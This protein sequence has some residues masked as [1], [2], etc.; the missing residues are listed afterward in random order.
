MTAASTPVRARLGR[1]QDLEA[2]LALEQAFAEGDRVSR[3]SWRRFI[4][5]ND[6][7]LVIDQGSMLAAAAILLTRRGAIAARLYSLA[8][9]PALRGHGYGGLLLKACEDAAL[10]NGRKF[11]RLEVRKSNT[12]AISLYER[13]GFGVIGRKIGYYADGEDALVMQKQLTGGSESP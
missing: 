7:V 12:H 4:G 9:S 5:K 6:A 3:R 2:I 13:S 11:L 8:V 1:I 10:K